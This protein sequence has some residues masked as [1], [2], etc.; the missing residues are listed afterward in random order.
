MKSPVAPLQH[1]VHL[2][3]YFRQLCENHLGLGERRLVIWNNVFYRREQARYLAVALH[4]R[5][6]P[7]AVR[8]YFMPLESG[9]SRLCAA[10]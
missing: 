6:E 5:E 4:Q 9:Q 2:G 7:L 1:G 8:F 10:V 3:L